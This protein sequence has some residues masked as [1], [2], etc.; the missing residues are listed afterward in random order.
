[1]ETS[2]RDQRIGYL[3]AALLAAFMTLWLGWITWGALDI[4]RSSP[5]PTERGDVR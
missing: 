4:S 2:R 1:M 5:D 3:I